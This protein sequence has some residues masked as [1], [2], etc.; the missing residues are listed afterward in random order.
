VSNFVSVKVF[1]F[2]LFVMKLALH[3]FTPFLVYFH[4]VPVYSP[5]DY[6]EI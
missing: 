2:T 3:L 1:N 4:I 6:R 5:V